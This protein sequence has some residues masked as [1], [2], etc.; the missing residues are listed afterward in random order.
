MVTWSR[1]R[2]V[3]D[4][5]PGSDLLP[6]PGPAARWSNFALWA[7]LLREH[8]AGEEVGAVDVCCPRFFLVNLAASLLSPYE[9][10]A[11]YN[12]YSV[13]GVL[14]VDQPQSSGGAPPSA[15]TCLPFEIT[16]H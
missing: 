7:R 4:A 5:L 10:A 15:G 2:L 11:Q 3:F 6:R 12:V 13:G 9:E 14:F 8:A 16:T 1:P